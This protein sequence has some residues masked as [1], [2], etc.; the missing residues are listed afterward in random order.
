[1]EIFNRKGCAASQCHGSGQGGLT[2][3]DAGTTHGNLVNVT[4]PTSGQV[5]VVPGNAGESYLVV[6][7]NPNPPF[8]QQMP[9]N[10]SPLDNV[11]M[12]NLQNWINQGAQ[13]N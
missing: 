6:K 4:S 13:N 8:G 9:L 3:G 12:T 7:V 10:G 2:M 5:R 11:D 1:M